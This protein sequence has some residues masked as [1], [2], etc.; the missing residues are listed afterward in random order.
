MAAVGEM[1]GMA[2]R[3]SPEDVCLVPERRQ[4]LTT[5]GGLDLGAAPE[6][7]AAIVRTLHGAGIRVTAFADPDRFQIELAK[8]IGFDGVEIHTGRYANGVG[9]IRERELTRVYEAASLSHNLGLE[10]HAGHG[11]DYENVARILQTPWLTELNIGHSI[12]AR[13]VFVGMETA[14]REMKSIFESVRGD[15]RR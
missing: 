8:D 14:V 9:P 15:T 3:F 6:E 4:E 5:E 7:L 13:S 11:L 2:I 1:V 12:V 10:V